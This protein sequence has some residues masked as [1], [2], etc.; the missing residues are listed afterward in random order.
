MRP[1]SGSRQASPRVMA[2]E[3]RR[4]Q[5][6]AGRQDAA[7]A[8]N[9][10]SYSVRRSMVPLIGNDMQLAACLSRCCRRV[11]A[12]WCADIPCYNG[13]VSDYGERL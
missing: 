13:D 6:E 3:A 10:M 8:V 1:D 9:R 11:A 12:I 2:N 4:A 5:L 7:R